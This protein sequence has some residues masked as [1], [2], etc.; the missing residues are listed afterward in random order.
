VTGTIFLGG[1]SKYPAIGYP[2]S[3]IPKR[4]SLSSIP[5]KIN[6][7]N[8]ILLIPVI[9]VDFAVNFLSKNES[10]VLVKSHKMYFI[11]ENP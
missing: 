9:T 6:K 5:A 2:A 11:P 7:F 4:G 10:D 3:T 8:K 1:N